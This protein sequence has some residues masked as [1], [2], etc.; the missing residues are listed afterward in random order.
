MLV[1]MATTDQPTPPD[2]IAQYIIDGLSRQDAE[3]LR[4]IAGY[5]EQLA[6]WRDVQAEAEDDEQNEEIIQ[7]SSEDINER[8]DDVPG[9]AS[10]V[11]KEINDNRYEYYQWREGDTVKSKYKA[12]ANSA[13]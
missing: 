12:P 6:E 3:D 5:A 10:V 9:K 2:D 4:T 11:I 1:K 8:P 7:E 13:E